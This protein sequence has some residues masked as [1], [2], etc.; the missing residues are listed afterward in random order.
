LYK[1]AARAK[2]RHGW[3]IE[4]SSLKQLLGYINN[5]LKHTVGIKNKKNVEIEENV[6]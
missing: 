3:Y 1:N 2:F 4:E 6:K 5:Y